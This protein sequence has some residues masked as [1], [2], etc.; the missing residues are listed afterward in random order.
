M[1]YLYKIV[2]SERVKHHRIEELKEL[3]HVRM[4]KKSGFFKKNELITSS[5]DFVEKVIDHLCK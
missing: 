1:L 5:F 4:K 3:F 2:V